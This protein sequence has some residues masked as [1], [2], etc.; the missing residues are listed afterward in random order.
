MKETRL[1]RGALYDEAGYRVGPTDQ[2][3]TVMV[4]PMGHVFDPV[5]GMELKA[6]RWST[7]SDLCA[8][9]IHPGTRLWAFYADEG[10]CERAGIVVDYG[11]PT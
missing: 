8:D 6:E 7:S 11:R 4:S 10:E 3:F 5:S 1:I 9:V 2:L